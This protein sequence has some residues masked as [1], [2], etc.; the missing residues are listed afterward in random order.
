MHPSGQ[1]P[2]VVLVHGAWADGS[3]WSAVITELQHAGIAVTAAPIPLTSLHDDVAAVVRVI[4]RT[5][6]PIVLAAHAYAGAVISAANHSRIQSLVFIAALAPDEGET[7]ADV[8]YRDPAHP[9][10]PELA[11]TDDGWIWLPTKAFGTAFAHRPRPTRSGCSP[12]S[13][14]PSPSHVSRNRLPGRCGRTCPPGISSPSRI[15]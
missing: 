2:T 6:G 11:P 4:E 5:D 14:G 8:F 10:A 15:G 13:N 3:S 7:V 12:R 9:Q 1:P